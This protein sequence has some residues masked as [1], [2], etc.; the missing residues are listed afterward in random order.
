MDTSTRDRSSDVPDRL[1]DLPSNKPSDD[2]IIDD[3]QEGHGGIL[4]LPTELLV[5]ILEAVEISPKMWLNL[6]LTH[7]RFGKIV[8]DDSFYKHFISQQ[9]AFL[10]DLAYSWSSKKNPRTTFIRLAKLYRLIDGEVRIF[11]QHLRRTIDN[12]EADYMNDTSRV[13]YVADT[14]VEV[15]TAGLTL[16]EHLTFLSNKL[17]APSKRSF[18]FMKS[19]IQHVLD[20]QCILLLR[21]TV[22]IIWFK[23]V[24]S[25]LHESQPTKMRTDGVN[26][27]MEI[28]IAPPAQEF[29]A[30]PP[31]MVNPDVW[32]SRWF[33]KYL[34][35]IETS[36]LFGPS[37]N[38][39]SPFCE[40]PRRTD[41]FSGPFWEFYNHVYGEAFG[42][43]YWKRTCADGT[44][45]P[46][47][48]LSDVLQ[49]R[50]ERTNTSLDLTTLPFLVTHDPFSFYHAKGEEL[51][52]MHLEILEHVR[53]VDF[54]ALGER[55]RV[56]ARNYLAEVEED[57]LTSE[58]IDSFPLAGREYGLK[59]CFERYLVTRRDSQASLQ[60]FIR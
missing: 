25:T 50:L 58:T 28:Q 31:A 15:L 40:D 60:N 9:P 3:A 6:A 45:I 5:Q 18:N 13:I 52:D 55:L 10:R 33:Y 8:V 26:G 42:S 29:V 20:D 37:L 49:E 22:Y 7:S 24:R 38:M 54:V 51:E 4:S 17:S 2:L 47:Y 23:A 21:W 30:F 12:R 57:E 36:L 44:R 43:T 41:R 19:V 35:K 56:E 48:L 16:L 14:F 46:F 27:P 34:F 32:L 1:L 53:A 11:A 39:I 59:E